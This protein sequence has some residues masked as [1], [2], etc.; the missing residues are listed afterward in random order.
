MAYDKEANGVFRNG[1]LLVYS[2]ASRNV[3]RNHQVADK[4]RLAARFDKWLSGIKAMGFK[5]IDRFIKEPR[6][7]I[8]GHV[9]S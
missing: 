1:Y 9:W 7:E 5:E 8:D 6:K 4:G 3:A 2:E